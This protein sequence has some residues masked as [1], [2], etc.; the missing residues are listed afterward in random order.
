MGQ[1]IYIQGSAWPFDEQVIA[2]ERSFNNRE[3]DALRATGHEVAVVGDAQMGFDLSDVAIA[4]NEAPEPDI[5]FITAH[6][7]I[8]NGR[9]YLQRTENVK[10]RNEGSLSAI[11]LYWTLNDAAL[12][13]P[14]NVFVSS[15][16]SGVDYA[17]AA[18]ALPVGSTLVTFTEDHHLLSWCP[19]VDAFQRTAPGPDLAERFLLNLLCFGHKGRPNLPQLTTSQGRHADGVTW[20]LFDM[21]MLETL[22]DLEDTTSFQQAIWDGLNDYL[23]TEQVATVT[24][25]IHLLAKGFINEPLRVDGTPLSLRLQIDKG[26]FL[27]DAAQHNI[28]G[29]MYAMAYMSA[30]DEIGAFQ[31]PKPNRTDPPAPSPGFAAGPS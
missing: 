23:T 22:E 14:L 26:R 19:S 29:P 12:K 9:H 18:Q 3:I 5:V 16:G 24:A 31:R 27:K 8:E 25:T 21:A 2:K 7:Y 28:L 17:N 13:Q 1:I 11:D 15:C 20:A 30:R 4:F 6:G 10:S